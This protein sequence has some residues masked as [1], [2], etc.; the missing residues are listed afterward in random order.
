MQIQQSEATAA[1]RRIPFALVDDADGKT[2]ETGI[3]FS[4]AEIQ[5]SKNGGA[6]GSFAGSVTELS[7]GAYY[8]EATQG[9][10]DTVGFLLIKIEKTGVRLVLLA[11]AQVVP[12][13]PYHA[14]LGVMTATSEGSETYG[15]QIR[16][17]AAHAAGEGTQPD[18]DGSFAYRDLADTKDRIAGTRSGSGRTVATRDGA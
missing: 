12:W 15:D 4:G 11:A 3:T 16:L 1:Q 9:E 13:D 8:Y 5:L 10:V 18:G 2:P 7:D 17:S 6:F 14:T